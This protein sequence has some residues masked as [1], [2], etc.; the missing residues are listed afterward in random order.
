M[1]HTKKVAPNVGTFT[2]ASITYKPDPLYDMPSEPIVFKQYT[3]PISMKMKVEY[4]NF[5]KLINKMIYKAA[6]ET[7]K[8]LEKEFH[9]KDCGVAGGFPHKAEDCEN[10]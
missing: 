1:K 8:K 7:E 3:L 6:A 10:D 5:D 2:S 9:Y 4:A